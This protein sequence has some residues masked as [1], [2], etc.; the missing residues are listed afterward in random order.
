MQSVP[1]RLHDFRRVPEAPRLA[2]CQRPPRAR[3]C[4]PGTRQPGACRCNTFP[5]RNCEECSCTAE[6]RRP[7]KEDGKRTEQAELWLSDPP[8]NIDMASPFCMSSRPSQFLSEQTH[9]GCGEVLGR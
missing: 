6:A 8:R 2:L 3:T 5:R 9:L 1:C 4:Q 7:T